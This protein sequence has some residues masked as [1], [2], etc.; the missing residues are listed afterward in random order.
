MSEFKKK[1]MPILFLTKALTLEFFKKIPFSGTRLR[2]IS[3]Q[4]LYLNKGS[5]IG[6]ETKLFLLILK[7]QYST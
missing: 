6:L 7:G 2:R 3:I 5:E 4:P 1:R